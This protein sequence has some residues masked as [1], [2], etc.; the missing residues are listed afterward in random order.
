[1]AQISYD[2]KIV[3]MLLNERIH[4]RAIAKK[5]KTNHMTITRALSKL[6]KKNVVDFI[7]QGKN[8]S[9]FLKDTVEAKGFIFM[10]E[11]YALI[12]IL[13]K[14][15]ALRKIIDKIQKDKRIKMAIIFGSFAKSVAKKDSDIDIFIETDDI[16]LKKGYS[17]INSKLSIKIGKL[18]KDNLLAKEIEKNHAIIKGVESYYKSFFEE[19]S[20]GKET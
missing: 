5:L 6:L 13:E 16:N 12:N 4:P 18:N 19:A 8:K 20:Q 11:Y 14:Y 7:Q 15:P 9:F 2:M 17:L 1:M 10:S 3:R